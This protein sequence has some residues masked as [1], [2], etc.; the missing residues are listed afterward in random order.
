[1]SVFFFLLDYRASQMYSYNVEKLRI[2]Y[3]LFLFLKPEQFFT[4][5]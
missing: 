3:Y 2:N 1:M 5:M 4:T